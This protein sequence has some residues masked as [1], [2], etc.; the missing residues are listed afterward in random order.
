M[1]FDLRAFLVSDS[2]KIPK[3]EQFMWLFSLRRLH[4]LSSSYSTAGNYLTWSS[5]RTVPP[6]S[7]SR[8]MGYLWV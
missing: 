5:R 4:S 6:E 2:S 3:L 7:E 1:Y 8:H